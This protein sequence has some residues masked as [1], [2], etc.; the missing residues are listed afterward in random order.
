MFT[1]SQTIALCNKRPIAFKEGLRDSNPLEDIPDAITPEVLIKGHPIID[2]NI[3]PNLQP[4]LI[5]EWEKDPIQSVKINYEKLKICRERLIEQYNEEFL[6]TLIHQATDDKCRYAPKKHFPLNIGDIILL[7]ERHQKSSNYPLAIV[8][9]VFKNSLG[10]V[11]EVQAFKGLTR[12]LVRRHVTSV[13]PYLTNKDVD[14]S[15]N[16]PIT[17]CDTSE[18]YDNNPGPRPVRRAAQAAQDTRR[19]LIKNNLL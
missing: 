11:T 14:L 18:D 4:D 9:Q 15:E 5:A 2:V 13:I 7:V 16:A 10:E 3:N 8:R 6:S 17:D 12:E 19:R 1:I